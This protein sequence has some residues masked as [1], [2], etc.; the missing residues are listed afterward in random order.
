MNINLDNIRRPTLLVD[1]AICKANIHWMAER[2]KKLGVKFR[3]HF[4]TH[5]SGLIGEWFRE[6]GVRAITVASVSMARYFIEKGWE[7][8]TIA[9]PLNLRESDELIELSGKA[10]LN[11][12]VTMSEPLES[13]GQ[14]FY[15]IKRPVGVFVKIDTG[16][17][18]TGLTVSDNEEIEIIINTCRKH[19][20]L[21]FKGFLTHTGHTYNARGKDEIEMISRAAFNLLKS[22][23]VKFD[24]GPGDLILSVGDTPACSLIDSFAGLDEMRP[25]NFVFYDVMQT[26]IGSC[27]TSRIAVCLACPVVSKEQSRK[28]VAIYGGAVHLSKESVFYQG[29]TIFGLVCRLSPQGWSEP[30][31]DCYISAVSQEH[32]VIKVSNS[33][34]ETFKPGDLLGI[35]PVHSCLTAQCM[36]NYMINGE[37]AEPQ[38]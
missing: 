8:I 36:G 19:S 22:L 23:K 28:E 3:P 12:L 1:E 35:L 30:L 29:K 2:A 18:R 27:D 15:G 20:L 24:S 16:Y 34:F 26:V 32:G 14:K 9:F 13:F 10:D 5:Q 6:E 11:I 7:D 17:H 25:G 38:M 37:L 21:T 33:V 4:K 31:D